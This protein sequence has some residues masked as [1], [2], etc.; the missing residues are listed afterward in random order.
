MLVRRTRESLEIEEMLLL[1]LLL[2]RPL[3]LLSRVAARPCLAAVALLPCVEYAPVFVAALDVDA[4]SVAAVL[5]AVADPASRKPKRLAAPGVSLLTVF[6]AIVGEAAIVTG[7]KAGV[8]A[9]C[10]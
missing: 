2:R 10:T 1:L 5:V 3:M 6:A 4:D 7:G 9:Y 8:M